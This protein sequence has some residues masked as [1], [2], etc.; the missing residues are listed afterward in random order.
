MRS[1]EY[2]SILAFHLCLL[3]LLLHL[4]LLQFLL[5]LLEQTK[6]GDELS[7]LTLKNLQPLAQGKVKEARIGVNET[8]FFLLKPGR[9]VRVPRNV[10]MLSNDCILTVLVSENK[11]SLNKRMADYFLGLAPD[12]PKRTEKSIKTCWD[13]MRAKYKLVSIINLITDL[14]LASLPTLMAIE[15]RDLLVVAI[16][17]LLLQLNKRNTATTLKPRR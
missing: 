4:T 7:A 8:Q 10:H 1:F 14:F 12:E 9:I 16:G 15:S 6:E 3:S 2:P 13:E 17:L 11:K 5:A